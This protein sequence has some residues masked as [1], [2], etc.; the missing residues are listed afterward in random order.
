MKTVSSHD[1]I[2]TSYE[3]LSPESKIVE[4]FRESIHDVLVIEKWL[5]SIF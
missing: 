1:L 2:F 5:L 4:T 3:E